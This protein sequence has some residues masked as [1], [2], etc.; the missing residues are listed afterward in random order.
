M[1]WTQ[2]RKGGAYKLLSLSVMV[3]MVFSLVSPGVAVFADESTET[4][5]PAPVT[6]E[7]PPAEEAVPPETAPVEEENQNAAPG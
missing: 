4:P 2:A 6:D 3:L 1:L 5:A 7:L